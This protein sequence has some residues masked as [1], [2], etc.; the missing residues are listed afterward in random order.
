MN[1][2]LFRSD[3]YYRIAVARLVIPPLRERVEDIIPIV[4][5]FVEAF[6]ISRDRT[7][8]GEV[9][10]ETLKAHRWTGNVRELRNV[11]ETT[12]SMGWRGLGEAKPKAA[13]EQ[14]DGTLRTYREARAETLRHFEHRYLSALIESTQGNASEAARRAKMDRPYLVSLLRKHGLR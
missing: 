9:A 4:D 7:P 6:G 13:G 14:S 12:M 10:L 8:F 3:L 11:V 5:H 2:G 1:Q